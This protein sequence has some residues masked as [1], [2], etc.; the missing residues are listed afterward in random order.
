MK[1]VWTT[2]VD[3][4]R[5][6]PTLPRGLLSIQLPLSQGVLDPTYS[7]FFDLLIVLCRPP[8]DYQPAS[9]SGSCFPLPTKI[10]SVTI[11]ASICT[12][13]IQAIQLLFTSTEKNF[14]MLLVYSSLISVALMIMSLPVMGDDSKPF[15]C[16]DPNH[17]VPLCSGDIAAYN[18][19][20]NVTVLGPHPCYEGSP[21]NCCKILGDNLDPDPNRC[22]TSTLVGIENICPDEPREVNGDSFTL[23]CL[24]LYGDN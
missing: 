1:S 16:P 8:R 10:F 19:K 24:R 22:C 21:D 12:A 17:P 18:P 9:K 15:L 23:D 13:N 14:N 3:I 11:I 2:D 7:I 6:R 5:L 20:A 4:G